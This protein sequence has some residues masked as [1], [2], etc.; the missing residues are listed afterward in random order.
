MKKILI[1]VQVD[2]AMLEKLKSMEGVNVNV[3]E[4][5]DKKARYLDPGIVSDVNYLFCTFPCENIDD[6]KSLEFIQV[7]SAG[8]SQLFGLGLPEKKIIASNARGVFD[9][10]IAEWCIAM[11]V[12]LARDMRGLVRNQEACIFERDARFQK[13]IRGSTVGIWGYGSIGRETARL[14]KEMGLTVYAMDRAY[15]ASDQMPDIYRVGGTGDPDAKI[16]AKKF[17]A[18]QEQEFLCDLDFLIMTMPLTNNTKDLVGEKELSCLKPTAYILNPARGQLINEQALLG[19]LRGGGIAGAALDT[20]YYYPMPPGHPLWQFP[21]VI[22]TP[23]ISG[24]TQS[25]FFIP[26]VW[27]IFTKNIERLLAGRPVLNR[28]TDEQLKGE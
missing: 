1:D 23:H 13:E 25:P 19:V 21:N 22:M 28:L 8:Y 12:N 24:S 4:Y 11:M 14:A 20:H 9:T 16:P 5:N 18:G 27:D 10:P 15:P 2:E 7:D 6:M 17:N 26:R 3:I